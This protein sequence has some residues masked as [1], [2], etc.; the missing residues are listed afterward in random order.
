MFVIF[1]VVA[2]VVIII[3]VY[4]RYTTN[5]MGFTYVQCSV[6]C[7]HHKCVDM[8]TNTHTLVATYLFGVYTLR[9]LN[10]SHNLLD[11]QHVVLLLL[12]DHFPAVSIANNIYFLRIVQ[13]MKIYEYVALYTV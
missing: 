4:L 12:S 8:S 6:Q 7:V 2:V 9:N 3:M 1:A 13:N 5:R 11:M 10:V